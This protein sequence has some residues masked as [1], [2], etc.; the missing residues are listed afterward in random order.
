VVVPFPSLFEGREDDIIMLFGVGVVVSG[1]RV[2]W[3]RKDGFI[4]VSYAIRLC[5]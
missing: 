1:G 4:I 3:R 5:L 2:V